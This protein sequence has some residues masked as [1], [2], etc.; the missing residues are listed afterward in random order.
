L[1][2]NLKTKKIK[3]MEKMKF[4]I[5]RT[6]RAG[7]HMGYLKECSPVAGFHDVTLVN[8]RRIW[9]WAGANSISDLAIKGSRKPNDCKITAPVIENKMMAIE[10][11]EVSENGKKELDSI[12]NWT[13]E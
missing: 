4:V 13:F 5:V 9:S 10:V 12:P 1:Y 6:D 7:V 8:T 11:I 2:L 3:N